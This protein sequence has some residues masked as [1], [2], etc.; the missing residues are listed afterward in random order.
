MPTESWR[1]SGRRGRRRRR[2]SSQGG[3]RPVSGRSRRSPE[4]VW[5]TEGPPGLT[6]PGDGLGG[7]R[8]PPSSGS[9]HPETTQP[10]PAAPPEHR[11]RDSQTRTAPRLG[12]PYPAKSRSAS[13]FHC[14][15]RRSAMRRTDDEGEAG[16]GEK[17]QSGPRSEPVRRVPPSLH[18]RSRAGAW[19]RLRKQTGK[20]ISTP[21]YRRRSR[22]ATGLRDVDFQTHRPQ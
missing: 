5:S 1:T 21:M 9:R 13:T 16:P 11:S 19:P 8:T 18:P 4:D 7:G 20:R 6:S 12:M 3:R 14:L 15:G 17:R 10:S 22:T 2:R